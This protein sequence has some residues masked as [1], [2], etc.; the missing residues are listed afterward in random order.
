MKA[1]GIVL[2]AAAALAA[3]ASAAAANAGPTA[4]PAAAEDVRPLQ[5]GATVPDL[6]LLTAAGQPFALRAA[7][8]E[9]PAV[10]IFYRGGWCPY[11]NR[12]LGQLQTVEADLRA[13]G[14]QVLA[15]S[16]DRPG[17]LAES[18][19]RL[20]VT[21]TLLSDRALAAARAFGIAFRVDD[22]TVETYR[23]Y[24]IDLEEASGETHHALPV[25]AVFLVGRDGAVR[26]AHANPDYKVRLAPGAL[27]AAARAALPQAAAAPGDP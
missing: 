9:R 15:V 1:T 21:Y 7:L 3:R 8:R 17:K 23:G 26:F 14:Y 2:L 11:C 19:A 4:L 24:G 16:P 18:A 22:A 6:A 5:A 27:L 25:P 13:L 20:R 12:H 10:L